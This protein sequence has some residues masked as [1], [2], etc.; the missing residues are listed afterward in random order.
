M[1]LSN[2]TQML[3]Q[4]SEIIGNACKESHYV[5]STLSFEMLEKLKCGRV[6]KTYLIK[7]NAS[8]SILIKLHSYPY[9]MQFVMHFKLILTAFWYIVLD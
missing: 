7:F 1:F 3:L 4:N 2:V 8:P 6:R 9:S 5:Y